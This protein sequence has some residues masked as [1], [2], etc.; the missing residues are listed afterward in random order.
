MKIA[1]RFLL[2]GFVERPDLW[3]ASAQIFVMSSRWEG[4]RSCDS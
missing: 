4:F 3:L 2:P 1:D